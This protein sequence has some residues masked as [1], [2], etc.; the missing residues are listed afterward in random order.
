MTSL[1]FLVSSLV[2]QNMKYLYYYT[3]SGLLSVFGSAMAQQKL[4][5]LK[6]GDTLPAS[7]MIPK[8]INDNKSN[9]DL[10]QFN[11]QLVILDF[12][13]TTCG[14][15][16]EGL[17]KVYSLQK[18]FGNKIKILPVTYEAESL[19]TAFMKR[20]RM[21]NKLNIPSV[22]E[23]RILSILFKHRGLPH[24]VWIF[25]G[26]VIAI[27]SGEYVDSKNIQLALN[28][29]KLNLPV[30]DDFYQYDYKRPF[31]SMG[32]QQANNIEHFINYVAVTGFQEG[33]SSRFKTEK[34]SVNNS[35]RTYFINYPI[36]GAYRMLWDG[37]ISKKYI[38]SPASS[39]NGGISPNQVVLEVKNKDKYLYNENDYKGS[40]HKKYDISYEWIFSDTTV[41][42]SNRNRLIIN[43]LDRLLGIKGRWEKRFIK[44]L[45]LVRTDSED[46][47]RSSGGESKFEYKQQ[48]KQLHNSAL[49]SLVYFLN[50][51]SDNPPVFDETGYSGGVDLDLNFNSWTDIPAVRNALHPYGLDLKEITRELDMFVLT[52][53]GLGNVQ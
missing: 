36:L 15:C 27:T 1:A 23:D 9:Y 48:I 12:W 17:P 10:I 42:L 45:I 32:N 19:V 34:D 22:V 35:Y 49:G 6:I 20:N 13:A 33:A 4:T 44:C 25:K 53:N 7:I 21:V 18:Q 11:D 14:A 24:E 26:R 52:E 41:N 30:K 37:L 39:V 5:N 16:I 38:K 3:L 31:L 51:F 40:W 46:K 29:D 47:I 2:Y 28:G 43:D 50:Y 8:I